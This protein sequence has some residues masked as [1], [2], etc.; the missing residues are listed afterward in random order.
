VNSIDALKLWITSNIP[1]YIGIRFMRDIDKN[2]RGNDPEAAVPVLKESFIQYI[3]SEIIALSG[4]YA[5]DSH[6]DTI[7]PWDIVIVIG[8]D[9]E[10]AEIFNISHDMDYMHAGAN[11]ELPVDVIV[12]GKPYQH[13]LSR[14]FTIGLLV[15]SAASGYN[16]Y[17][18]MFGAPFSTDYVTPTTTQRRRFV[19][20]RQNG[21][22]V[23][24]NN[25]KYQFRDARFMQGFSTGAQWA[26]VDHHQYWKNLRDYNDV[27]VT[28]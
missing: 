28:F 21:F 7:L 13:S 3:A 16:F 4:N 5:R 19:K 27:P 2:T 25:I 1:Q 14:D 24:I 12:D 18:S 20:A 22:T 23:D 9:Q 11:I 15:F 26:G 6:D 10:L 17:V 8:L